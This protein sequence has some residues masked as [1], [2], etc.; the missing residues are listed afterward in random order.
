[1]RGVNKTL[2]WSGQQ[3]IVLH[4]LKD[5][6]RYVVKRSFVEEKY[7][8]TAWIFNEAYEYLSQCAKHIISKPVDAQSPIWVYKSIHNIYSGDGINYLKVEIPENR[9]ISFDVRKWNRILNLSYI[10]ESANEEK[11]FEQW[12]YKRGIR[13]NLKIFSTSFYPVEKREIKKSW[14]R[15]L[16]TP[17]QE[18]EYM[19]GMTWE[20]KDEWIRKVYKWVP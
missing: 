20:L 8:E 17:V 1:M 6:G 9:W 4:T 5:K 19:Q 16:E 18:E 14:N 2:M 10:G 12:L 15:L 11:E 3:D 7:K 13:D